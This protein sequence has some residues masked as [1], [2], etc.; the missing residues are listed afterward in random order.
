MKNLGSIY[1]SAARNGQDY[2]QTAPKGILKIVFPQIE[3]TE[4]SLVIQSDVHIHTFQQKKPLAE[5]QLN[6]ASVSAGLDREK[7]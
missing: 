3:P 2:I 6:T 5:L 1:A 7:N 4:F